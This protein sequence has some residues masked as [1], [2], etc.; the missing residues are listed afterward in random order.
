[1]ARLA[2][3]STP[4][5]TEAVESRNDVIT[6]V[7]LVQTSRERVQ[8]A[9]G[10]RN[11]TR[12]R[13]AV[14]SSYGHGGA[15]AE[16]KAERPR[17]RIRRLPHRGTIEWRRC[18]LERVVNVTQ[19][20]STAAAT[21]GG[22]RA[23]FRTRPIRNPRRAGIERGARTPSRRSRSDH[24]AESGSIR[25]RRHF[26]ASD[27]LK[28]NLPWINVRLPGA[29][30]RGPAPSPIFIGGPRASGREHGPTTP[31]TPTSSCL[32]PP[33]STTTQ[34]SAGDF[35]VGNEADITACARPVD[36]RNRLCRKATRRATS[37]QAR[38]P[39]VVARG[40]SRG[41]GESRRSVKVAGPHGRAVAVSHEQLLAQRLIGDVAR[42]DCVRPA[43][44]SLLRRPAER[45]G[46]RGEPAARP[47]ARIVARATPGATAR[48]STSRYG[49]SEGSDACSEHQLQRR[50]VHA[51]CSST[52]RARRA[53]GGRISC[54]RQ[55][56]P[57]TT[58]SGRG[59]LMHI[60]DA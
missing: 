19:D 1:M 35:E 36:A 10:R 60:R 47:A 53:T 38:V 54:A 49:P 37:I 40:R 44:A 43:H 8:S 24:N 32:R 55:L 48:R 58:G 52:K 25:R 21:T 17:Q 50:A 15:S 31:T 45:L 4:H 30:G 2:R 29:R 11:W 16:G 22:G 7:R 41:A 9:D 42:T 6:H 56:R 51:P 27:R 12:G 46:Q 3:S 59:E 23:L 28:W 26:E 20:E 18:L 33:C 13:K 34:A 14:A 57:S 5:S 39:G